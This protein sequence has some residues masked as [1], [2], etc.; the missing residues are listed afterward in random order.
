MS[1]MTGVKT[2]IIRRVAREE[3]GIQR[4]EAPGRDGRAANMRIS[5]WP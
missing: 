3:A 4:V 1:G 5:Q 2:P